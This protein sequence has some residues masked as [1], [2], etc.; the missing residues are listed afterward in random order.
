LLLFEQAGQQAVPANS[1][2]P[3]S[4]GGVVGSP[5]LSLAAI[6]VASPE[7]ALSPDV[8][9]DDAA[10]AQDQTFATA[11]ADQD[12]TLELDITDPT[13]TTEVQQAAERADSATE[14]VTSDQPDAQQHPAEQPAGGEAPTDEPPADQPTT[15]EQQLPAEQAS[16]A[17]E[18]AAPLEHPEAAAEPDSSN[19]A[20]PVVVEGVVELDTSGQAADSRSRAAQ[21]AQVSG[22]WQDG[23]DPHMPGTTTGSADAPQG[24]QG[25]SGAQSAGLAVGVIVAA[26]IAGVAV[27]RYR[28]GWA[29]RS[30]YNAYSSEVEMRGLI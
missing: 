7:L 23:T 1:P 9:T 17:D 15:Q 24:T 21:L 10:A 19:P 28:R 20:T 16:A 8:T 4:Y 25:W 18:A 22:E 14:Q 2:T 29:P 12:T 30:R 13:D 5:D 6:L 3:G 26:C 27:M 11:D